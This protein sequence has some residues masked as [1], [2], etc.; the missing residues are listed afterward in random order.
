MVSRKHILMLT[1]RNVA[2]WVFLVAIF[3]LRRA[4]VV[5]TGNYITFELKDI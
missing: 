4:E 5:K 3:D 2:S 1:A